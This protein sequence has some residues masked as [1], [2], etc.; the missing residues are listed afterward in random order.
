MD[1]LKQLDELVADFI[2]ETKKSI[3]DV[4]LL[5][6]IRWTSKQALTSTASSA[7]TLTP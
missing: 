6:F 3:T 7:P 4:T 2:T 5:E 1:T